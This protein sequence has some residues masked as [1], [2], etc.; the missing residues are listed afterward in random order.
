MKWKKSKG[1]CCTY[2]REDGKIIIESGEVRTSNIPKIVKGCKVYPT[3]WIF[4]VRE[5][6]IAID[7]T[8]TLKEA[9]A[10]YAE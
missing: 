3:K 5:N 2:M 10:K 7:R 1:T 8:D 9:K 4:E 6:G